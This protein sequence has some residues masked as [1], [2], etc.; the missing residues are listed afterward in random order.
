MAAERPP[1]GAKLASSTSD[2]VSDVSMRSFTRKEKERLLARGNVE[3]YELVNDESRS[4]QPWHIDRVLKFSTLL[5]KWFVELLEHLPEASDAQLRTLLFEE[6][7]QALLKKFI[8]N[9][10]NN[11]MCST[12]RDIVDDLFKEYVDLLKF[13]QK[14][15]IR[16]KGD[17]VKFK[18]LM[19]EY[20]KT[21]N[22]FFNMRTFE[23]IHGM[24]EIDR[25][26]VPDELRALLVARR[27]DGERPGKGLMQIDKM[28][29]LQTQHEKMR[30]SQIATKEKGIAKHGGVTAVDW[31]QGKRM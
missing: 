23:Q 13:D 10:I 22:V 21:H 7:P 27:K 31:E 30:A 5:R 17:E 6:H 29:A 11:T 28:T 1:E 8:A 24:E 18:M 4:F 25:A 9:Y 3:V 15:T 20:M 16:A 26:P 2:L 14:A 12:S 19:G